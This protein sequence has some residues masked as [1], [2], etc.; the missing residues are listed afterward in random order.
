M[1]KNI[2]LLSIL[3]LTLFAGQQANGQ[4][5]GDY[6]ITGTRKFVYNNKNQQTEKQ[7]YDVDNKLLTFVHY[8][9]DAAGN[10]IETIKYDADSTL[11]VR[12]I[13]VYSSDNQRTHCIIYDSSKKSVDKRDYKYN[14]KGQVIETDYYSDSV[15]K[16]RVMA[17]Y[18]D[19]G[20]CI[21]KK[22]FN[23]ENKPI[24]ESRF[25]YIYKD[26]NLVEK[27]RLSENDEI[28]V[29][30]FYTYDDNGTETTYLRQS[31]K[32]SKPNS[33]RIFI[34]NNNNQCIGAT[35]YESTK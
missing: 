10:K 3:L 23:N 26:E 7:I 21:V 30:T 19:Q 16:K 15:L 2:L 24:S 32:G 6:K 29:K 1:S 25:K 35:V 34:Y 11:W 18:S 22:R 14:E 33:K 5:E 28:V 17:E 27:W 8:V 13:Y 9:Y 31:L 20:D 4:D 12:Y